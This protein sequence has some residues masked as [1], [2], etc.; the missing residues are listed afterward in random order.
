MPL[1]FFQKQMLIL[2]RKDKVTKTIVVT[3]NCA[4]VG[5]KA[6]SQ[7]HV[8]RAAMPQGTSAPNPNAFLQTQGFISETPGASNS[9]AY[10]ATKVHSSAESTA[11][12]GAPIPS[13]YLQPTA[14]TAPEPNSYLDDP[15]TAPN[16]PTFFSS[17]GPVR[18][19]GDYFLGS[20]VSTL[21]AVLYGLAWAMIYQHLLLLEPFYQ[22]STAQGSLANRTLTR[23][24][25][26]L[27]SHL[28]AFLHGEWTVLI[29]TVLKGLSLIIITLAPEAISIHTIGTCNTKSKGCTGKIGVLTPAARTIEALLCVIAILTFY[30]IFALRKRKLNLR[31]NPSSI[32]GLATLFWNFDIRKD[33]TST[34]PPTTDEQLQRALRAYRFS[35]NTVTYPDGISLLGF[36]KESDNNSQI[37]AD[38]QKHEYEAL[39]W[40]LKMAPAHRLKA[41]IFFVFLAAL[42]TLIVAYRY[43]GGDN[44]FETF[45]DSQGFG[46]RFLFTLI[47]VTINLFWSTVFQGTNLLLTRIK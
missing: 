47:G 6:S 21:V 27:T 25:S 45:M 36:I 31:A 30:L 12:D 34:Q 26:S 40:T 20:Y 19:A 38:C 11:T 41:S 7:Q 4:N 17:M 32:A 33:F 23:N 9:F 10:L 43:T 22:L 39:E 28:M 24:F 8:P 44:G 2:D 46:V 35:L 1:S 14:T 5:C 29:G 13:V 42:A 18:T 3:Y 16:M 15:P 37:P